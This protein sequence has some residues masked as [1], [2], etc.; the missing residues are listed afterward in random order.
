MHPNTLR[1]LRRRND[2]ACVLINPLQAMHPNKAAP[3]DSTLV[4]SSRHVHYDK[5]AYADWLQQ[6]RQV[7]TEKGIAL[8][9]DEVFMGFRLAPGGAQE[10]FNVKADL[11][12]YGKTL[13]GGL[14]VGVICGLSKW[15]R[16]F[17]T[18]KPGELCFARG[19]FNAHPYVMAT[20]NVFLNTLKTPDTKEIYAQA[21]QQW[22]VRLGTL[23]RRLA[24][25]DLPVQ[26]AGMETVW[27][28]LYS[29]P[30]RYNWMFQFYLRNQG[31]ALSWVGSG[32]MIFN[33][34]IDDND[35]EIMNVKWWTEIDEAP[36]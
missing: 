11:V 6:L 21:S 8:I 34:A 10:Y 1:V 20:M 27:S 23:N 33:F 25:A 14:P 16:R 22:A 31:I 28:I 26:V 35:F 32:R 17:K 13:G 29:T 15:M 7:C 24:Q 12:T 5:G 3:T 4:D 19:T 30:S 9:M 18:D 2:I 36:F